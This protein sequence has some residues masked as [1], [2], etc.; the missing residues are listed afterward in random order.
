M[1]VSKHSQ[2]GTAVNRTFLTGRVSKI[3][4]NLNVQNSTLRAHETSSNF[5]IKCTGV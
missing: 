2:G 1:T 3:Q 4:R 5:P